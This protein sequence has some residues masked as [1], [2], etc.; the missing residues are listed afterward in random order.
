MVVR[1]HE[2]KARRDKLADLPSLMPVGLQEIQANLADICRRRLARLAVT[3]DLAEYRDTA[4]LLMSDPTR[5]IVLD[6]SAKRPEM[7]AAQ[8]ADLHTILEWAG[9]GMGNLGTSAPEIS[10]AV[11]AGA[12]IHRDRHLIEVPV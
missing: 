2:L 7:A 8:C 11:V 1:L 9:A 6:P 12:R 10:V 4:A 3:P 5:R